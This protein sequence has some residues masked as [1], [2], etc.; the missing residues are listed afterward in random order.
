MEEKRYSIVRVDMNY[1]IKCEHYYTNKDGNQDCRL[2]IG[3]SFL[4]D[5]HGDTREQF[6]NKI[7]TAFKIAIRKHKDGKFVKGKSNNRQCAEIVAEYLG[8]K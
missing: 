1:C 8:V 3:A 4:C 2:R 5:R 6:I 7:Q